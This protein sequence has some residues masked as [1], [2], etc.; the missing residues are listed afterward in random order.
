MCKLEV[1]IKKYK[2]KLMKKLLLLLVFLFS[3]ISF[4]HAQNDKH[5]NLKAM[6]TAF[7]TQE[8]DLTPKEAEKF[9]PIYNTYDK[10]IYE[11]KVLKNRETRNKIKQKGGYEALNE[12]EANEILSAM[13]K[14]DEE[15]WMAKKELI[16]QLKNN[17]PSKKILKLQRVEYEFNR[18]LLKEYHDKDTR[19]KAN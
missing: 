18:K 17:I 3:T 5:E 12:K 1:P 8:L 13:L 11:L 4:V 9:W 6:K 10:K 7:I 15:E 19:G 14:N 2:F 16:Q